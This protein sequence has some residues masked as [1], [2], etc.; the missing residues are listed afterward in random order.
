MATLPKMKDHL[1]TENKSNQI[2]AAEAFKTKYL[3]Q[4]DD[5]AGGANY[6]T[7]QVLF[8][9]SKSSMEPKIIVE[10]K[11][12]LLTKLSKSTAPM[13]AKLSKSKYL[14]FIDKRLF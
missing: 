7:E 9:P 10:S 2:S 12:K 3:Q 4:H 5:E 14:F 1:L 11:S 13:R 6:T 8:E